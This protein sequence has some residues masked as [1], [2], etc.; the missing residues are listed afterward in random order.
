M[1]LDAEAVPTSHVAAVSRWRLR[2]S[3][4]SGNAEGN[5]AISA[6]V[7]GGS[8]GEKRSSWGNIWHAFIHLR[9][10]LNDSPTGT[11]P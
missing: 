6:Q 7:T 11:R 4:L 3:A 1:E 2:L 10:K 9:D 5:V 8:S